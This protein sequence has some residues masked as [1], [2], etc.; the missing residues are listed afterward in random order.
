MI[1]QIQKFN[2][3][4][5]VKDRLKQAEAD[6]QNAVLVSNNQEYQDI[7]NKF[8]K[9]MY[10]YNNA[11]GNDRLGMIEGYKFA[12]HLVENGKHDGYTLNA[13]PYRPVVDFIASYKPTAAAA[14]APGAGAGATKKFV[15]KTPYKYDPFNGLSPHE[16]QVLSDRVKA[17]A[18]N[19]ATQLQAAQTKARDGQYRVEGINPDYLNDISEYITELNKIAQGEDTYIDPRVG[20]NYLVS[21]AARLGLNMDDFNNYMGTLDDP[22]AGE[23]NQKKLRDDQW[24]EVLEANIPEHLKRYLKSKNNARLYQKG[25]NYKIVNNDYTNYTGNSDTYL[26]SDWNGFAINANGDVVF[27]DLKNAYKDRFHNFYTQIGQYVKDLQAANKGRVAVSENA[28]NGLSSISNNDLIDAAARS[29]I[30]DNRQIADVSAYFGGAGKEVIAIDTSNSGFTNAFDE[31]GKL[32]LNDPTLKFIVRDGNNAF[33]GTASQVAQKLGYGDDYNFAIS[34]DYTPF[35]HNAF[36]ADSKISRHRG[37]EDA[38][39]NRWEINRNMLKWDDK[40]IDEINAVGDEWGGTLGI[41]HVDKR[42]DEQPG[43]V[44]KLLLYVYAN[45]D[46]T[47]TEAQKDFKDTWL[48]GDISE[49][50]LVA[51]INTGIQRDKS[52]LQNPK[53]YNALRQFYI[54]HRGAFEEQAAQTAETQVQKAGGIIKAQGG[55]T[56]ELS[57]IGTE[58]SHGSAAK[59]ARQKAEDNK[60]ETAAIKARANKNNRTVAQQKDVDQGWDTKD[61]L[62]LTALATDVAGLIMAIAGPATSGAGTIGAIGSGVVSTALDTV[63]DFTDTGVSKG[64]AWKNLL[65]NVGLTAGAGFGAKSVGVVSKVMKYLPKVLNMAAIA[66]ITFD[67]G[68]HNTI[69]KMTSGES[70]DVG[71]WRNIMMV[72]RTGVNLGSAKASQKKAE[73][74]AKW[75]DAEFKK[76]KAKL[77]EVSDVDPDLMYVADQDGNV[78][79]VKKDVV[80]AVNK[81]LATGK[82]EDRTEA[83]ALLTNAAD[84]ANNPGAGLDRRQA[85]SILETIKGQK[86]GFWKKINVFEDAPELERIREATP[87]QITKAGGMDVDAQA[88]LMTIEAIRNKNKFKKD[89]TTPRGRLAMWADKRGEKYSGAFNHIMAGRN[90]FNSVDNFK[91]D[92]EKAMGPI[93]PDEVLSPLSTQDPTTTNQFRQNIANQ[94]KAS[95]EIADHKAAVAAMRQAKKDADA[96]KLSQTAEVDA[97]KGVIDTEKAALDALL[98]GRTKQAFEADVAAAQADIDAVQNRINAFGTR[99]PVRAKS[100]VESDLADAQTTLRNLLN[101]P[102]IQN[103][104][105]AKGLFEYDLATGRI[106]L[107]KNATLNSSAPQVVKDK[108][109]QAYIADQKSKQA[110]TELGTI[111]K[112]AKAAK[113]NA[114]DQAALAN[115]QQLLDDAKLKYADITAAEAKHQTAQQALA[116]LQTRHQTDLAAAND[117]YTQRQADVASSKRT[118]TNK[119]NSL[120]TDETALT[121]T[122]IGQGLRKDVQLKTTNGTI[123]LPKGTEV[124]S[125]AHIRDAA[126][127]KA[128]AKALLSKNAIELSAS[129][130]A[131][132]APG[133]AKKVFRG[134]FVDPA[135]NEVVLF[136]TGGRLNSKYKHLRK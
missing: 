62:R 16:G 81:K 128:A 125:L 76:N 104:K 11:Y 9:T 111:A 130:V 29:G 112:D 65:M 120:R 28:F 88:R 121:A 14:A 52:I 89:G 90:Y 99:K 56:L 136:N 55:T 116:D 58:V 117:L 86:E 48:Y 74:G 101:D 39:Y 34:E 37:L 27:Q 122:T 59:A 17:L 80:A 106:K 10:N 71:D 47:L 97:Q 135:T 60:Q 131:Q 15:I 75:A 85:E 54:E 44:A 123:D 61:T 31:F 49:K 25:N 105:S 66:G 83:I 73:K 92:M 6:Y 103:N 40:I 107:K 22:T 70:L 93:T 32:K 63:A 95:T 46:N 8:I 18:T 42:F 108:M 79:M 87:D 132:L 67:P 124:N 3:G 129:E 43:D 82:A 1:E 53:F 38:K 12:K 45:E 24:E 33:I 98:G 113:Q 50:D 57:D 13:T 20:R 69:G 78:S 35:L 127:A 118:A 5:S 77:L 84:D 2:P 100:A 64:Q 110:L 94:A 21:Q 126:Q 26:D 36:I 119:Y 114:D 109:H 4:G 23:L 91:N 96:L 102:D 115:L 19:I 51:L 41:K 72:L 30:L 133:N 68:V 134:G 7:A